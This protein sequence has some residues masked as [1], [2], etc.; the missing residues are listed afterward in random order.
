MAPD[1]FWLHIKKSAG[2]STRQ[3]LGPLY[4]VTDRQARVASIRDLPPA[5]WNDG[6]NNYRMKLGPQQFRRTEYARQLLWPDRWEQMM[7]VGFAREPVSRCVSTFSYLFDPQRGRHLRAYLTYL[8]HCRIYPLHRRVVWSRASAFDAYLDT[9][10]WQASLRDGPDPAAPINLHFSTHSNPM[11]LDVLGPD[12]RLNL[13]HLIRLGSFE[14]GIDLCYR[15]MG[16]ARPDDTRNIRRNAG[17]ADAPYVPSA[18]Q[19]ARIQTL[20]AADFDLYENA[21]VL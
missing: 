5:E 18:R 3:A 21:L 14:A 6:L 19:R 15:E 9:L 16:V 10:A 8:L 20:Y 12:G 1:F 17:R 4:T 2:Q 11:S 13:S 7:R